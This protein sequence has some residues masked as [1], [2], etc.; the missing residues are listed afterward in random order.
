MTAD[1]WQYVLFSL[2]ALVWHVLL[3][4]FPALAIWTK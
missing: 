3:V 2:G 1:L 4:R